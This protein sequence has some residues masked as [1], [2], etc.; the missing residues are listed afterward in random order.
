MSKDIKKAHSDMA[1]S[2]QAQ[3]S[4]CGSQDS[5]RNFNTGES[6]RQLG[7]ISSVLLYGEANAIPGKQLMAM[8]NLRDGRDI[9]RQVERERH[10]GIP[11]CATTNSDSPGYYLPYSPAELERYIKSLDRRLKNVRETREAVQDAY[12]RATGQTEIEAARNE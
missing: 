9:T 5:Y 2:E 6:T 1:V 10:A 4:D 12:L 11:I 8:L 3:G 7:L